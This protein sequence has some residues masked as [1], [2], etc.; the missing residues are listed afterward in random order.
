MTTSRVFF[1]PLAVRQTGF[2][3]PIVAAGIPNE[4]SPK[5]EHSSI[6]TKNLIFLPAGGVAAID[7]SSGDPFHP[8]RTPANWV[9]FASSKYR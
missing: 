2:V 7:V 3:S 4:P 9:H 6:P 8:A 1:Y 5:N